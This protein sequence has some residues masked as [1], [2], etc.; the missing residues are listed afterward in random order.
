MHYHQMSILGVDVT[1]DAVLSGVA[2]AGAPPIG[3]YILWKLGFWYSLS[4]LARFP[5]SQEKFKG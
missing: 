3:V 5:K 4:N 1:D 2:V